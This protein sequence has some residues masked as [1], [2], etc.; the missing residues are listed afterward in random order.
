VVSDLRALVVFVPLK[1]VNPLNARESHFTRYRRGQREREAL[2]AALLL[3]LRTRGVSI[4]A[5]PEQ[6][7]RVTFTVHA[8]RLFDEGDNLASVA[9][10]LRDELIP[11]GLIH[12]DGPDSGHLFEYRQV[13]AKPTGV[14]LRV[15]CA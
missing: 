6:P 7:K 11:L 12:S 8:K 13:V 4:T 9:K 2:A 10:S 14:E 15:E 1:P 5:K 3:E